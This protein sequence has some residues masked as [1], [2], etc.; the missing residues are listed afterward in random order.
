MD[1]ERRRG[2]GG[3]EGVVV[4]VL[5]SFLISKKTIRRKEESIQ[6]RLI[7]HFSLQL[8]FKTLSALPVLN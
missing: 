2:R 4:A 5:F 1:V 6:D 8:M 3:G 7:L